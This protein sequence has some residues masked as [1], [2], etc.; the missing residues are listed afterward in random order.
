MS[1]IAVGFRE[2]TLEEFLALPIFDS[3]R[4]AWKAGVEGPDAFRIVGWSHGRHVAQIRKM[5]APLTVPAKS[6]ALDA[7]ERRRVALA[8]RAGA[9]EPQ[10]VER[11][12]D[13][14]TIVD[15]VCGVRFTLTVDLSGTFKA[16]GGAAFQ[17]YKGEAF[18]RLRVVA[19]RAR[20]IADAELALRAFG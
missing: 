4:D 20:V 14:V 15:E 6:G 13:V 2:P 10:S 18:A 19:E 8:A 17:S 3:P 12:G 11:V 5:N 7:E 16:P 9:N 1:A